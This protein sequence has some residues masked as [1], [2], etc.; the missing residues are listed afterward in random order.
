MAGLVAEVAQQG[1]VGFVHGDAPL[2]AGSVVGFSERDGDE[3]IVM[4]SHNRGRVQLGQLSQEVEG[5]PLS[6][7]L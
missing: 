7:I 6:R 2:L 5:Q 4:P 3:A 1:A